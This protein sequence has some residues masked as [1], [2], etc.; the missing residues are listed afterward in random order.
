[1]I[2][3]VAKANDATIQTK[4]KWKIFHFLSAN[5]I[6]Q[7]FGIGYDDLPKSSRTSALKEELKIKPIGLG[8]EMV[9]RLVDRTPFRSDKIVKKKSTKQM[10]CRLKGCKCQ[11]FLAVGTFQDLCRKCGHSAA[12]HGKCGV[13]ESTVMVERTVTESVCKEAVCDSLMDVS[14]KPVPVAVTSAGGTCI[15]WKKRVDICID[16]EWYSVGISLKY[17]EGRWNI[18]CLEYDGGRIAAQHRLIRDSVDD[19]RYQFDHSYFAKFVTTKLKIVADD[20]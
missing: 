20:K 13:T 16:G 7:R 11:E 10:R 9:Q 1:V 4:N 5:E 12:N 15:E 18:L 3:L 17:D 19:A 14:K 8:M 2:Y 6:E